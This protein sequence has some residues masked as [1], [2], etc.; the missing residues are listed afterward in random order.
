[1][2]SSRLGLSTWPARVR[3]WNATGKLPVTSCS[4]RLCIAL[5]ASLSHSSYPLSTVHVT[6][7]PGQA[8]DSNLSLAYRIHPP[9]SPCHHVTLSPR[10]GVAP[11]DRQPGSFRSWVISY[12]ASTIA[13]SGPPMGD[14]HSTFHACASSCC[15][16]IGDLFIRL[17]R[18][19]HCP[20][21]FMTW[22]GQCCRVF[23]SSM[24]HCQR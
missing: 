12:T 4:T 20:A 18:C 16:Q 22:A 13:L 7:S 2:M 6:T 10:T 3:L 19:R 14:R 23:A 24:Q 15:T 1:M 21:R 8:I 9:Y 11:D 17:S 5:H